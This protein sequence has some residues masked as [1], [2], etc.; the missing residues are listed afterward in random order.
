M[1]SIGGFYS[2]YDVT[3]TP[4][5]N[6]YNGK[7][8]QETGFYDYGWRQYMPD[9]GRWFG[10]DKLAEAYNFHSPYAYVMNN[11]AM[12]FDPDGRSSQSSNWLQ[13]MWDKTTSYSSWTNTGNGFFTGGEVEGGMSHE[14]FTSF[15]NFLSSGQTGNYRYW[16]GGTGDKF[17]SYTVENGTRVYNGDPGIMHEIRI[18]G[19]DH[20]SSFGDFLN[21]AGN[22]NDFYDSMGSSLASN[23]GNTRMGTNGRIYF[24]NTNGRVFYGNQYVRTLS[25]SEYGSRI[26]KYTGPFGKAINA[27][28]IVYGASQDGWTYGHNAKVATAGVIGGLAGAEVGAV[29]GAK[30]FGAIGSFVGPEGTLIGG[31][32]G[33]LIGGF[34]GGYY[35]GEVMENWADGFFK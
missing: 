2:V 31:I 13:D 18:K 15:Y 11:P 20:N 30:V 12:M 4:L 9:L 27:G 1:N 33:G 16:T 32:V 28:K 6:K 8:L 3:G 29:A 19:N 10:V 21:D 24:P 35:G 14:Q 26:G 25:W 34:A 7:E 17:T 23:A 5:N 22:F